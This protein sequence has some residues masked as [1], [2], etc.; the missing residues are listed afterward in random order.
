MKQ[1]VSSQ[2]AKMKVKGSEASCFPKARPRM[3][4]KGNWT[5]AAFYRFAQYP[6]AVR[7]VG[8]GVDS[9][10]S[11]AYKNGSWSFVTFQET[12]R[13]RLANGRLFAQCVQLEG[14]GEERMALCR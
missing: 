14:G 10:H 7:A 3:N 9:F 5:A 8:G 4:L 6:L 12:P 2:N 1:R 13:G 11:F